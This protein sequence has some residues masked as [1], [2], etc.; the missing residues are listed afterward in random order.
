LIFRLKPREFSTVSP[1]SVMDRSSSPNRCWL[2][3]N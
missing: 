2:K 1:P 3:K